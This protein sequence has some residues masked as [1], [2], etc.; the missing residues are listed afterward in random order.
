MKQR[1]L[2][3]IFKVEGSA[4]GFQHVPFMNFLFWRTSIIVKR[5]NDI[6]EPTYMNVKLWGVETEKLPPAILKLNQ[7]CLKATI[8]GKQ[9]SLKLIS[10]SHQGSLNGIIVLFTYIQF[11]N[12]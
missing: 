3:G 2:H 12:I 4:I 10:R 11:V 9:G 1:K 5:F 6:V 7:T 8:D